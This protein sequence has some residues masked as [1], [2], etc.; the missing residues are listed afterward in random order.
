MVEKVKIP[1]FVKDGIKNA[2]EPLGSVEKVLKDLGSKIIEGATPPEDVK[3]VINDIVA[4]VRNV[5]DDVEKAFQDGV[6][7][8]LSILK[9]ATKDEI[10]S[11]QKKINK[12]EKEV[13]VLMG[14]KPKAAPAKKKVVKKAV[15]KKA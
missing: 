11:L 2:L 15:A 14:E 7:K 4:R 12:I 13:R 6:A 10:G 8:T 5:R 3:K 1:V 9:V